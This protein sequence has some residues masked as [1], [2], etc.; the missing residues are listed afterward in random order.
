MWVPSRDPLGLS[1]P[2]AT[3]VSAHPR[4][5]LIVLHCESVFNLTSTAP[6]LY[7]VGLGPRSVCILWG[8][9]YVARPIVV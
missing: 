9:G 1:L 7:P 2:L 8:L 6:I 5:N 4:G 3:V